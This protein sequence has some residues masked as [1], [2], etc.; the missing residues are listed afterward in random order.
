M[1]IHKYEWRKGSQD[2]FKSRVLTMYSTYILPEYLYNLLTWFVFICGCFFIPSW[3]F[4]TIRI[5]VFPTSY[6]HS[7]LFLVKRKYSWRVIF[8]YLYRA[9]TEWDELSMY[10]FMGRWGSYNYM[11]STYVNIYVV[12]KLGIFGLL[13]MYI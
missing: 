2:D 13:A 4:F 3:S 1:H 6:V 7:F 10:L 9:E 8:V 5:A 12:C 11:C